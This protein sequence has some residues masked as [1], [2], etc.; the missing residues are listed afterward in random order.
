V[1]FSFG[2]FFVSLFVFNGLT[3]LVGPQEEHPACKKLS[4]EVLA[5][6]PV[7]SEVLMLLPPR[8]LLLH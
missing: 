6:L 4:D 3:L 1:H 5:W 2:L 7:C 8:H